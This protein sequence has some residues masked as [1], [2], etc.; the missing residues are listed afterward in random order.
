M[1]EG[2]IKSITLIDEN[3]KCLSNLTL[4]KCNW[5]SYIAVFKD[6]PLNLYNIE[7]RGN[8]DPEHVRTKPYQ[9]AKVIRKEIA[10]RSTSTMPSILAT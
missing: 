4:G 9:M 2:D 10:S 5:K 3:A 7:C 8:H 6:K 1:H